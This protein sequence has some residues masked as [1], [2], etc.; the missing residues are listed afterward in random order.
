MFTRLKN[1]IGILVVILLACVGY[2]R[3]HI[4]KQSSSRSH[5]QDDAIILKLHFSGGEITA[6]VADPG[7]RDVVA[8][9]ATGGKPT[10]VR[11]MKCRRQRYVNVEKLTA[12]IVMDLPATGV[13]AKQVQSTIDSL[14]YGEQALVDEVIVVADGLH[15]P[16]ATELD[17]YLDSLQGVDARL[18]RNAAVGQPASRVV[19]AKLAKAP[20][21]VFADWRV[22]GTVGWLPP[23]LGALAVEPNAIIMP[24]LN[25]ASDQASLTMTPERL[26]A[27][28]MWPL[29]VRMVENASAV[30]TSD[31]L[32]RSPALRGDLFAVRRDFW[33]QLGGYNDV[34]GAD[35][36]AANLELAI[37][38]W[39]CGSE[40]GAGSILMHRCSHVGVRNLRRVVR[41][42]D[43][44][45]VKHIALLWFRSRRVVM[46]RSAVGIESTAT[47]PV[48]SGK[49][50][51]CRGIET[52]FSDV[53]LVPLPSMEAI[54]FGQLHADSGE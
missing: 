39:Q 32:Y 45:S 2:T 25:E 34:L 12:T 9:D 43:P 20:V 50:R 24:H 28:Y 10:D 38:A 22:V 48:I 33:D 42:V 23:L 40:V 4:R 49:H 37:R 54:H 3:L 46:I 29:S 31:G 41:V 13:D 30:P 27:A 7:D 14:L 26:L 52:Y 5:F 16:V 8:A 36:A 15:G 53:A 44:T 51:K 35:P 47:D 21:V 17:H 18:I 1:V 6:T 11:S 19:G